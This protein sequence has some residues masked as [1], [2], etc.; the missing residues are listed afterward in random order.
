MASQMVTQ[1]PNGLTV[2]ADPQPLDGSVG[3]ALILPSGS[4]TDPAHFSGLSTLTQD[5]LMQGAGSFTH[6]QLAY[7]VDR[8]G[9]N[10]HSGL[11]R[12]TGT[13]I[14]GALPR[15][16]E[17]AVRLQAMI[18]SQPTFP[19]EGLEKV[20]AS[21]LEQL[22]ALEDQ[23]TQKLF[24]LL[25]EKFF[26]HPFGQ[27]P[28]GRREDLER[29]RREDVVRHHQL[30]YQASGGVLA[31]TGC[32]DWDRALEGVR[33]AWGR[34]PAGSPPA[35]SGPCA[36]AMRYHVEQDSAQMQ[37]GLA[38][39]SVAPSHPDY[40]KALTLVKVM[41]GGMSSRL[42]TE[43]REKRGLVYNV[44][45][46]YQG[47]RGLGAWFC[48]AGTTPEKS[49]ETLEV[50]R[51]EMERLR[52]GITVEEFERARVKLAAAYQVQGEVVMDRASS[53][54]D[55]WF[56]TGRVQT[57]EERLKDLE[58]LSLEA[59][60]AYAATLLLEATVLTLGPSGKMVVSAAKSSF[61]DSH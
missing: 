26:P 15:H 36:Q 1:L 54:A 59:V 57:V 34:L 52:Q 60:N 33:Q 24:L 7:E 2:L 16:V 23:P 58:S 48:Y 47:Y 39:P 18:V 22:A 55:R 19:Q 37:I 35:F 53:L 29:I 50:M 4:G 11:G 51:G 13:W 43:V 46:S 5:Y 61:E 38:Y 14:V 8:L 41:S 44:S 30:T 21:A 12:E 25:G 9:L 3:V 32:V 42:F 27:S 56:M 31:V 10:R 40:L 6:R 49:G 17:Q 20:R 28:Y 45:A